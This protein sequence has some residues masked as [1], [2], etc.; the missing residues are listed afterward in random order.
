MTK[1]RG[2]VTCTPHKRAAALGTISVCFLFFFILLHTSNLKWSPP[3]Q[4]NTVHHF[5]FPNVVTMP[6]GT[7]HVF[8][9]CAMLQRGFYTVKGFAFFETELKTAD[10][11]GG[12][13]GI[14]ESGVGN[15]LA[16]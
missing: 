10:W 12:E 5:T 15:A 1:K 11:Y 14:G 7:I 9:A 2:L 16:F 3:F 8:V 6:G 13:R 4:H